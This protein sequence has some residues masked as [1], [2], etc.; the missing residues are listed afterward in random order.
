MP[1]QAQINLAYVQCVCCVSLWFDFLR[2]QTIGNWMKTNGAEIFNLSQKTASKTSLWWKMTYDE[3]YASRLDDIRSMITEREQKLR[4]E[5]HNTR[6]L[7]QELVNCFLACLQPFQSKDFFLR[8]LLIVTFF[9]LSFGVVSSLINIQGKRKPACGWE[10]IQIV[11]YEAA[12][13]RCYWQSALWKVELM[14]FNILQQ[15][16]TNCRI[17]IAWYLYGWSCKCDA[18]LLRW[19]NEGSS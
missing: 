16:K 8:V 4:N 18:L 7:Y 15:I 6:A 1:W 5:I 17:M 2:T 3:C 19:K 12:C 11:V 10:W 9:P 13:N 14:V